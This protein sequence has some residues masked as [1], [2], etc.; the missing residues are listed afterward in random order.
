MTQVFKLS[1]PASSDMLP[2]TRLHLLNLHK[3]SFHWGTK[4]SA[5]WAY[6]GHSHSDPIPSIHKAPIQDPAGRKSWGGSRTCLEATDGDWR[7]KDLE[8]RKDILGGIYYLF[9]KMEGKIVFWKYQGDGI[10]GGKLI[11]WLQI[12]PLMCKKQIPIGFILMSKTY[13]IQNYFCILVCMCVA[14]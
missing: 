12:L 7:K 4:Y 1:K 11:S 2:P 13:Q 6:G 3:Q 8:Y 9:C 10:D 14:R 5:T